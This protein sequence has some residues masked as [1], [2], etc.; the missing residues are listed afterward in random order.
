[1]HDSSRK[2]IDFFCM[3]FDYALDHSSVSSLGEVQLGG[4]LMFDVVVDDL[5]VYVR[6]W[7]FTPPPPP[8]HLRFLGGYHLLI[9]NV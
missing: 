2:W 7:G 6:V 3:T 8:P 1:M 5:K 4:G 9:P